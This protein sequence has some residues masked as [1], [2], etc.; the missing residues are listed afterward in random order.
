MD[1][2]DASESSQEGPRRVHPHE[3]APRLLLACNSLVA[4]VIPG[5]LPATQRTEQNQHGIGGF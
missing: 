1:G 5:T 4:A 2:L 3:P